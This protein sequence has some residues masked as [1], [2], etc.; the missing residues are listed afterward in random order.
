[1]SLLSK[2]G[3]SFM[4]CPDDLQVKAALT[5]TTVLAPLASR[6]PKRAPVMEELMRHICSKLNL[7]NPLDATVASCLS[8]T[9]YSVACTREFTVPTLTTFN[10]TWH[11]K[12]SNVSVR[13]DHNNLEATVLHLLKIKVHDRGGRHIL[14]MP[15]WH[16]SVEIF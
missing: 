12:L 14:V 4:D 11:I 7:S 16:H 5:G 9:F 3:T 10:P 8:T 1:M 15:G 6:H 2:P 13:R